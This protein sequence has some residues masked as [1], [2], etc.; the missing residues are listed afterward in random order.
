VQG[1][2]VHAYD[3]AMLRL[4]GFIVGAI[5]LARVLGALPVVGPLFART[6]IFGVWIAALLLSWAVTHYGRRA[7]VARRDRSELTRLEAVDSPYNHG[8]AG[9]LL[10]ARGSA[11]RA[12]PHLEEAVRG[13]PDSAE[14][15]YRL[16]QALLMLRKPREARTALERC[17]ALDEEH[18]YGAAQLR[19]AE[20]LLAGGEA[21]R[22]LEVLD[23]V[24]R[25]HGK[26]P[27]SAY[28]RGVTLRALR[29]KDEA[30]RSFAEVGS[31][32]ANAPRFQRREATAWATRAWLARIF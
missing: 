13:E 23:V 25:N 19:L 21:A 30:R 22:A 18:A 5:V 28:R 20:A 12:V 14:W 9:A 15:R 27:E 24:E 2:L 17:V 6:G 26:S 29:K 3:D 32:A 11:R 8:K 10:L 4:V 16:G 31:L 1:R 7:L